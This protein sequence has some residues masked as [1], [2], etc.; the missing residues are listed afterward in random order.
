M[1]S[2][3]FL[4]AYPAW[5]KEKLPFWFKSANCSVMIWGCFS[6]SGLGIA[7]QQSSWM[8]WMTR[9]SHQ[10]IFSSLMAWAYSMTTMSR[11]I[12]LKRVSMRTHEC[13]GSMR[14]HFHTWIGHQSP[15]FNPIKSL[16]D[17]LEKT[18]GM[19]RLSCHQYK[20]I[21]TNDH[22]L[23]LLSWLEEKGT[24]CEFVNLHIISLF[25]TNVPLTHQRLTITV[26]QDQ[27]FHWQM[28]RRGM[29]MS[30]VFG[31]QFPSL[32][33]YLG[34]STHTVQPLTMLVIAPF[35]TQFN[36]VCQLQK[37]TCEDIKWNKGGLKVSLVC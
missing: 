7:S 3:Q 19:V 31:V 32:C 17:V 8:Y 10:W 35:L 30:L 26:M 33:V 13:L 28:G 12:R 20:M 6:W 15:D 21:P 14:S 22:V 2:N 24:L 1:H 9:L 4:S 29:S 16:W 27:C 18:E 34:C 11:F 37:N 5:P 23:Y 25:W 36:H